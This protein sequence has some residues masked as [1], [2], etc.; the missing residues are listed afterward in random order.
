ME[1][2]L[3]PYQHEAN[4]SATACAD[5]CPACRWALA[6]EAAS[7]PAVKRGSFARARKQQIAV[8]GNQSQQYKR[9]R[10]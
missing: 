9:L 5:D 1:A 4:G 7:Q 8:A 3:S 2:N 10:A 6:A